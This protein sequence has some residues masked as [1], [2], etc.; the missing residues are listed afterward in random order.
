MAQCV[1]RNEF[2]AAMRR[3]A[4]AVAVVATDGPAGR[5]AVTVS[6][7]AS[8]SADPPLVLACI[9]RRSPV[10]NAIRSNGVF[11]VNLLTTDQVHIANTFAGRIGEFPPFDFAC[12]HWHEIG[13]PA[14]PCLSDALSAFHCHL[15]QAHD[16]GTHTVL[17]GEVSRIAGHEAMPLIY[18]HAAYA[19]PHPMM[20]GAA[21]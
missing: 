1:D 14:A 12:A 9:S 15:H 3:A 21:T 4:T 2:L 7:V 10:C 13:D 20:T 8:V 16:A 19:E 11:T 5:L 6:A 17:I 18:T